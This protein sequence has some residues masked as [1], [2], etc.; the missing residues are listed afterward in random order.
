[1]GCF[2]NRT[3][4]KYSYLQPA[5]RK[6]NVSE[7]QD[8]KPLELHDKAI[9]DDFFAQDP[10]ETSELTFTNLFMW[11]YRY[12]PLWRIWGNCLLIIIH[13]YGELVSALPPVGMGDKR[14]A[15]DFIARYLKSACE[16]A[17]IV[18]V[19]RNFLEAHVDA[20]LFRREEDRGNSDYVYRAEDLITLS[21]NKF[22]KKKN[23]V[24]QFVK[25]HRFEYRNLCPELVQSFLEL[26]ENWCELRNCSS[27]TN[28]ADEDQAVY[29]A[30][31]H[32]DWLGFRGGAIMMEGQ[33]TAFSLGEML[34][35]NTAVIHIEKADP[36]I[37]GLYAAINNFFCRE[38]WSEVE[39]INREQD[40][41]VEGLR[42]AK[43]SYHPDHMVKKYTLL[44]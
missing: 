40:L 8:F 30:L 3:P 15:L 42:K 5:S 12:R 44:A 22:H 10:P 13:E 38:A 9:F 28:L 18:R 2:R 34:N 21:G 19:S 43:E 11:R 6:K 32:Y 41:G 20:N 36:A 27:D 24:N 25:K 16:D 23:L 33:V 37:T 29:E 17:R 14:A 39:Y 26:Q 35:Q 4:T 31:K 7:F 1:M